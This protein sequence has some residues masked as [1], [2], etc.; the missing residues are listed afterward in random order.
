MN[1]LV[2]YVV[3]LFAQEDETLKSIQVEAQRNGLPA[4]SVR[5]DEGRLLLMLVRATGAKTAVEIGTLAGYSGVWIARGLPA[6]GRLYTLEKSSKHA[7]VAREGFRRA[8]VAHQVEIL[9][10]AA[11]DSLRKINTPVDFVFIDADKGSY[12]DYLAWA[13][14]HLRVGGMV[15]AH[16]A[17]REGRIVNPTSEE[18]RAMDA[19]N[20]ALASQPTLDST[21]IGVGDGMA[22]GIKRA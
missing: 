10:G 6:D 17:F 3:D 12:P 4:I 11:L 2:S 9:E 21:I 15:A 14:D 18:D 16:N 5:P 19:F 7:A 13:V 8:G 22:I 1:P 20:R